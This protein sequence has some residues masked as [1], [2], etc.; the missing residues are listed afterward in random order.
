[1]LLLGADRHS[2]WLGE[3]PELRKGDVIKKIFYSNSDFLIFSHFKF[4]RVVPQVKALP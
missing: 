2:H 3:D 4:T 1:M